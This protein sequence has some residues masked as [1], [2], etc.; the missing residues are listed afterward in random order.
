MTATVRS[1]GAEPLAGDTL[2]QAASSA[3]VK[4]SEPP[5]LL[6]TEIVLEAGFA[7]PAVPVKASD[8]GEA[9]RTGGGGGPGGTPIT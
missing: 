7:P 8:V 2:S 9:D 3:A 5:P 6:V 1:C 4:L